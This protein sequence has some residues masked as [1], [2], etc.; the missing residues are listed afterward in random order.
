MFAVTEN[1][2]EVVG[3]NVGVFMVKAEAPVLVRVVV[4]DL[5]LFA[6]MEPK[7]RLAGTTLTVPL[8]S[9]IAALADLVT[10]VTEVAVSVAV[11]GDGA[12]AGAV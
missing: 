8:V 7:F 6:F 1:S 11:A 2:L 9:V 10:S 3:V 5:L 12:A 4:K